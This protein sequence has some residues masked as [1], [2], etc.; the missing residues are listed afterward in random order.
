MSCPCSL[1]PTPYKS[2]SLKSMLVKIGEFFRILPKM[3]CLRVEFINVNITT[4]YKVRP[5]VRIKIRVRV[6]SR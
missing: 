4:C 5:T 1:V 6:L 2:N 3:E